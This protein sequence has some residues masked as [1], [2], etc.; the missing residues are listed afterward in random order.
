MIIIPY[1]VYLCFASFHS[2]KDIRPLFSGKLESTKGCR[3][4]Q[5]PGTATL[6]S[7]LEWKIHVRVNKASSPHS[8]LASLDV[9]SANDAEVE[10]RARCE[11]AHPSRE[12]AVPRNGEGLV[13]GEDSCSRYPQYRHNRSGENSVGRKSSREHVSKASTDGD[14]R[15]RDPV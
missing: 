10:P 8:D 7:S 13:E 14:N 3:H 12:V 11:H 2:S 15:D 9:G 5:P 4:H 1:H 6:L